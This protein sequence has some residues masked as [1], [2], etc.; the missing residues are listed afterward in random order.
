MIKYCISSRRE[1][2]AARGVVQGSRPAVTTLASPP[3]LSYPNFSERPR[4]VPGACSV[5]EAQ[6]GW[7]SGRRVVQ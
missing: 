2:V 7:R 6:Q 3:C 1:L 5:R 4:A